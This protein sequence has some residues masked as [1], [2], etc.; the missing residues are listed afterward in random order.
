MRGC[1][2]WVCIDEQGRDNGVYVSVDHCC[3]TVEWITERHPFGDLLHDRAVKGFHR[4]AKNEE[5]GENGV[6]DR[7]ENAKHYNVSQH[8]S[9]RREGWVGRTS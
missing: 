8:D 1:T 3:S 2:E 4:T 6:E 9:E 7:K 5:G